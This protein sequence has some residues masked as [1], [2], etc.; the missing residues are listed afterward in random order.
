MPRSKNLYIVRGV[1]AKFSPVLLSN[2]VGLIKPEEEMYQKMLELLNLKANE[3][4]FIDDRE[5][6]LAPAIQLGMKPILFKD[7]Q[8]LKKELKELSVKARP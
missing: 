4:V 8:Q 3:C 7:S 1:Y 6:H 2:E 5:E